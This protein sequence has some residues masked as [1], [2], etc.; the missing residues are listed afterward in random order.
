MTTFQA[1]SQR[2]LSWHVKDYHIRIDELTIAHPS[3]SFP[4]TYDVTLTLHLTCP[5]LNPTLDLSPTRAPV[6]IE[7][8]HIL[9][10]SII[11]ERTEESRVNPRTRPD[12]QYEARY[13]P[14]TSASF[15]LSLD[16]TTI[17]PA[18]LKSASCGL[19][20]LVQVEYDGITWGFQIGR[21]SCRERV[22]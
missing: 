6:G 10:T 7:S 8:F 17:D 3:N 9:K 1:D 13:T 15:L 2:P 5:S 20:V 11:F 21:A 4:P 14:P 18:T 19:E 16:P 22:S 12:G